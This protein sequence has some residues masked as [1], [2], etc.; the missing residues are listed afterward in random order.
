M[1]FLHT[2]DIHLLDL[3][4]ATPWSFLNKRITGGIN[5]ALRRGRQHDA[6]LFEAMMSLGGE[7]E[8]ERVVVTGDITNLSLE[9]EFALCQRVFTT[10]PVPVTV[11]PGNHDAYTP[12]AVRDRL[13][14]RYMMPFMDGERHGDEVY[15]FLMREGGVAFIGVSSAVATLPFSATGRV[16]RP[17]LERLATMLQTAKSEGLVRVVLIHHPPT[18]GVSKAR[19]DLLDMADF[20]RV[21]AEHGAELVLHGHEHRCVETFLPGP[22]HDVP[23][24]GIAAGTSLSPKPL[25]RASFSIYEV[26]PNGLQRDLYAWNGSSF[27]L[28]DDGA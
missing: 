11:V 24:H 10:L 17:Q 15:P 2:S 6:R 20:G 27:D 9:S 19:H 13:F 8:V 25:R 28:T 23:V 1:R 16:G 7:L 12:A 18:P 21:I 14:E 4:G 26:G 22:D 3:R 5:L